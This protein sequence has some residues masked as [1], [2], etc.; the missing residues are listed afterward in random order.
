M[1]EPCSYS[2]YDARVLAP[3][4]Q[5]TEFRLRE[6][7]WS[8]EDF[9]GR[10]VLD[11]GSNSGALSVLALQLGATRVKAVDPTPDF[12]DRFRAVVQMHK[13]NAEVECLS[14]NQLEPAAF[15]ADVVLFMEVMHWAVDQGMPVVE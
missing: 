1:P 13:L 4:N 8:R 7:F 10:D 12:V 6:L 9:V 14:L 15:E 11:I 2:R 3:S 5:E